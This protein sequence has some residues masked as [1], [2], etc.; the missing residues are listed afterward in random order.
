MATPNYP[1]DRGSMSIEELVEHLSAKLFVA[2][3]AAKDK[4]EALSKLTDAVVDGSDVNDRELV[5][6]MLRNREQLGS[7]ALEKGVAFPHGR[8]LA[9]KQLTILFA[10]SK[11]GVNFDSEDG[12]PT[13]LFFLILA[14][15]Q[16]TGN[17]YLQ[18]LG[19][20]A[21]LV[22][23]DEVCKALMEIDSYE[24]M[25]QTLKEAS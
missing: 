16:D 23:K 17:Y 8:S 18:A 21:E 6:N 10:R 4:P 3:F 9:V 24:S 14:P 7:T 12:K 19:K 1:G 20:I 13:H 15:P 22:R 11:R 2:D 25:L 5:L